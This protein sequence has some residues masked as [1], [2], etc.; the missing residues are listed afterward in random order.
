MKNKFLICNNASFTEQDCVKES[1]IGLHVRKLKTNELSTRIYRVTDRLNIALSAYNWNSRNVLLTS[2]LRG[3]RGEK[4]GLTY[5]YGEGREE[6]GL[7][8]FLSP[9]ELKIRY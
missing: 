8:F 9:S 3:E 1:K 4:F 7:L 6:T 5:M 2:C